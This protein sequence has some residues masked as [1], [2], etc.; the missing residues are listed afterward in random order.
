[1][2]MAGLRFSFLLLRS[3]VGMALKDKLSVSSLYF[4]LTSTFINP[5]HGVEVHGH[6]FSALRDISSNHVV[7]NDAT[8]ICRCFRT[9]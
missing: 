6:V 9:I 8:V 4:L 5:Q 7:L 3:P 2:S 1:M